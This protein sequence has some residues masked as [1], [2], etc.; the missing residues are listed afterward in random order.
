MSRSAESEAPMAFSWSRRWTRSSAAVG[1]TPPGKRNACVPSRVALTLFDADRAHFLDV[2]DA[3]EALL[4]AVLL[5][6]AHAVL[7]A[8]GEH[9]GHPRVLLDQLFQLVR[10]DEQLVKTAAALE[11]GAAALVAADRL[12]ERELAL[13]VAVVLDP[14][15]V[16]RLHGAF[17]IGLEL[18]RVHEL[19]AVFA[20]ERRELGGLRHVRLLARAHA[21]RQALRK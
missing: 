8:L 1:A 17:R 9:L 20:Q 11:A 10:G 5:Q 19:L 4:H 18:R 2:R 6:G 15:L 21:L 14:V 7:E 12:V 16:D 3:G 13:V